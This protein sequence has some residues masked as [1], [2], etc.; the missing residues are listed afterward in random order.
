MYRWKYAGKPPNKWGYTIYKYISNTSLLAAKV[1]EKYKFTHCEITR[2][3]QV[4][5]Q[6]KYENTTVDKVQKSTS[7][8]S[9]YTKVRVCRNPSTKYTKTRKYKSTE[10]KESKVRTERF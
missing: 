6:R 8:L 7:I 10:L 5:S 2:K 4:Y 1:H 3:E 9:K